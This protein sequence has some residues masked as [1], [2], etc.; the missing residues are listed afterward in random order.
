MKRRTSGVSLAL[1]VVVALAAALAVG[2]IAGDGKKNDRGFEYAIGLWGDLPYY[3][4]QATTGVPNL[5]ADMNSQDLAFTVHDGDLKAGSGING[6]TTTTTCANALYQQ[7]LDYL[8]QLEE[9]AMFTPGDNDWTDC[10]RA[11]NGGFNSL[12]RLDYERG[13]FFGTPKSLGKKTD[14]AEGA[15]RPDLPRVRERPGRRPD[16]DQA[17]ACVEN[18]RWTV[19]KVTYVTVNVPGL[20]QQPL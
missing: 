13:L 16:R 15:D 10:D 8:N 5:I 6:S 11:A 2:A 19:K 9:P 14:A 3:D 17:A 4:V 1:L 7:G 20:V 18:R 12:E